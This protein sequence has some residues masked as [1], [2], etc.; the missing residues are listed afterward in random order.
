MNRECAIALREQF[1]IVG[2]VNFSALIGDLGLSIKE[3]D[4]EGF[5]GALV[6]SSQ[7]GFVADHLPIGNGWRWHEQ[8]VVVDGKHRDGQ[9]RRHCLGIQHIGYD[10]G[11][12]DQV[13][14]P[15][16]NGRTGQDGKRK[17]HRD[18][19]RSPEEQFQSLGR[20]QQHGDRSHG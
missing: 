11:P 19:N 5:E 14:R 8:C 9:G 7:P 2:K 15:F 4:S 6:R 12:H 13:R 10:A 18:R 17:D 20:L 1:G 3:V 16:V